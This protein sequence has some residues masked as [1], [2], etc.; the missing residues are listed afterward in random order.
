MRLWLRVERLRRR[1]DDGNVP[2]ALPLSERYV[3]SEQHT[4][5]P[6]DRPDRHAAERGCMAGGSAGRD[7]ANCQSA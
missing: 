5:D 6:D 1:D 7:F 2:H 4:T 3:L